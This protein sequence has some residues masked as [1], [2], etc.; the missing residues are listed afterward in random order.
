MSDELK[1][2][3]WVDYNDELYPYFS[4]IDEQKATGIDAIVQID[5]VGKFY[6]A[7]FEGD[8]DTF[9]DAIFPEIYIGINDDN[10]IPIYKGDIVK[11]ICIQKILDKEKYEEMSKD[12]SL[13]RDFGKQ[14]GKTIFD[15][16]DYCIKES[17]IEKEI[18]RYCEVCFDKGH[19]YLKRENNQWL[20]FDAIKNAK[21]EVVGNIHQNKNL[22]EKCNANL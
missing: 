20:Y 5:D 9:E 17:T 13:Q 10:G 16:D 6:V 2:R 4:N 7:C 11:Y 15:Y 18:V 21:I 1:F 8:Y 22:L 14:G 3:V 12:I 19:F